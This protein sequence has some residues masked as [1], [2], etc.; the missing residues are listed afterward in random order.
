[1][2]KLLDAK[3]LQTADPPADVSGGDAELLKSGGEKTQPTICLWPCVSPTFTV[4]E[5]TNL[6][7]LRDTLQ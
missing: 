6:S 1:M 5:Q 7:F 3:P 2:R 4:S